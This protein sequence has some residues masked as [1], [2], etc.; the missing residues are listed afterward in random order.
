MSM[1]RPREAVNVTRFEKRVFV[2]VIKLRILKMRVSWI[3]GLASNPVTRV[4][5][6]DTGRSS[7]CEDGGGGWSFAAE[8]SSSR[9]KLEDTRKG[10][11]SVSAE[12]AQPW[13]PSP[14]TPDLRTL[15]GSFSVTLRHQIRQFFSA[16]LGN[17]YH[18]LRFL[19]L[20]K[21]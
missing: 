15:R 19:V 6:R 17:W 8:D 4:L 5:R 7:T 11:L 10:S 14:R 2:V 13:T 21:I 16:G 1:S 3:F 20:L 12:G 9:Q 18:I